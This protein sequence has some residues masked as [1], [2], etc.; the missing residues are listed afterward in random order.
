MEETT[1]SGRTRCRYCNNGVDERFS[2]KDLSI[3]VCAYSEHMGEALKEIGR[4]YPDE[5]IL[6]EGIH[7][8]RGPS[9]IPPEYMRK[10]A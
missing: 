5:P 1:A 7:E 8:G 6:I 2:A 4:I 10:R 3:P 9:E